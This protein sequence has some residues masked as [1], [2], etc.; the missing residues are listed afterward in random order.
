[1]PWRPPSSRPILRPILNGTG[2]TPI[3]SALA[4]AQT[5]KTNRKRGEMSRVV[6][7]VGSV[8]M[9]FFCQVKSP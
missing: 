5:Y 1:M 7:P 3:A 4:I 9:I 6:R 8:A 2:L